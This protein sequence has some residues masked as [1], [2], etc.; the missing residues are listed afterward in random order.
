MFDA[1]VEIFCAATEY[2]VQSGVC[3]S[4]ILLPILFFLVIVLHAALVREC[5]GV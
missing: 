5:E 4:C 2:E 1:P 3:Q